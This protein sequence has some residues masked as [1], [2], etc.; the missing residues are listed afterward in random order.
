MSNSIKAFVACALVM[1]FSVAA[2]FG[3]ASHFDVRNMDTK[4]AACTDFYQYAN[5]GWLSANP[6]PPAYPAWGV[7]NILNEKTR[8]QLHEILE[9]SAKNTKAPKGSSEQKVG[10]YYA[11]CMDEAKIEADGLKPLAPEFARIAKIDNQKALQDEI[12]HLHSIGINALFASGS[13]Q[14]FKNS[15]EVT[16]EVIQGGLGLPERDYYTKTDDKSKSTRAEY[17]KHVAKMFE[18]MGDD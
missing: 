2:I 13:T 1:A 4:T 14:D 7:A 17:L 3:Q 11:T 8:D 6:I 5:G 16:A 12:G 15:A 10:D 18:L 9:A